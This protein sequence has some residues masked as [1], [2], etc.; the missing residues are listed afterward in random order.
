M[1]FF[2]SWLQCYALEGQMQFENESLKSQL[3]MK[4][5]VFLLSFFLGHLP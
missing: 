2:N 5:E 4:K 3:K 1:L